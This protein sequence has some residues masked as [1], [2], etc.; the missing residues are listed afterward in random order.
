MTTQSQSQPQSQS[1]ST[2]RPPQT[3][4]QAL[5]AHQLFFDLQALDPLRLHAYNGSAL[6]GMLYRSVAELATGEG[7]S[8]DLRFVSDPA[9]RR[10]LATLDESNPRGQDVPRPYV[11]DPPPTPETS[12]FGVDEHTLTPGEAF[13]FGI[14]LFGDAI[15]AFPIL[16]MALKRAEESGLGRSISS[17]YSS[18]AS[19]QGA[20]G[21]FRVLRAVVQNPLTRTTQE[22]LA[23]GERMVMTPQVRITDDDV[24]QQA[25][26]DASTPVACLRLHLHT[27]LT[28]RARGDVVRE[29]DFSVLIHRLIERLTQLS[30]AYG[31]TLLPC[32]PDGREARNALLHLA[33]DVR[34]IDDRTR[35]TELR[36]YSDRTAAPTNLS[37]ITGTAD[38]GCEAGFGPFLR[39][40]RWGEIAHA[41]SNT[42]K[43]N[44]LFR[45]QVLG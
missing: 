44:G 30:M 10:L 8:I 29:V 39:I 34:L 5:I 26:I 31:G 45:L 18:A 24:A 1:Q 33:D 16:V 32:L 23:P 15:E 40:L 7:R 12:G 17:S 11:I 13:S 21:R 36:G 3:R 43:G 14:T 6:R 25:N 20:R 9:I 38:F 37:G 4:P 42:V 41:G 35:W 27:P 2:Q 22:F 28:L 19:G